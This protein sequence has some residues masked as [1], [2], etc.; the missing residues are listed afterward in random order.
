MILLA[1]F[2]FVWD[3]WM[4]LRLDSVALR[5][6]SALQVRFLCF[7]QDSWTLRAAYVRLPA[8][9]RIISRSISQTVAALLGCIGGA[10]IQRALFMSF[11]PHLPI[12]QLRHGSSRN[13]QAWA[14]LQPQFFCA[15]RMARLVGCI[16]WAFFCSSIF[17]VDQSGG[18]L[19]LLQCMEKGGV[20]GC[21]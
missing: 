13:L 18:Q 17:Q 1:I 15:C 10:S 12:R 20:G 6:W 21:W 7:L 9:D 19:L 5:F 3:A 8:A 14:A 2:G 11:N 16:A 4:S